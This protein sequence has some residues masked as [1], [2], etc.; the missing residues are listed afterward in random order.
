MDIRVIGSNSTQYLNNLSNSK[1]KNNLT[2]HILIN[3]FNIQ[4]SLIFTSVRVALRWS[5]SPIWPPSPG[6][7]SHFSRN[8]MIR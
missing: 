7:E 3:Y 4:P 5:I 2:V 8:K 1:I 6:N